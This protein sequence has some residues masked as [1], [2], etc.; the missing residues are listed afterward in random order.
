MFFALFS[1]LALSAG[2]VCTS[3]L[4]TPKAVDDMKLVY[5]Q[6]LAG[7]GQIAPKLALGTMVERGQWDCDGPNTVAPNMYIS[8]FKNYRRF[9]KYIEP[10]VVDFSSNCKA[11]DLT[12]VGQSQMKKLGENFLSYYYNSGLFDDYP[13]ENEVFVRAASDER[14]IRAAQ[15][16]M[17]GM[18]PPAGPNSSLTITVDEEA[19]V[20]LLYPCSCAC[21]EINEQNNK[22]TSSLNIDNDWAVVKDIAS[23]FGLDKSYDNLVSLAEWVV[24]YGCANIKNVVI[25][26]EI[27]TKC[28]E[29][30]KKHTYDR[31]A[32]NPALYASFLMREFIR[33]PK[34]M[35]DNK[36]TKFALFSTSYDSIYAV[37]QLLTGGKAQKDGFHFA[38]YIS[39]EVY[40][41]GKGEKSVRFTYNNT[42][43]KLEL[44]GGKDVVTL[45][46][47]LKSDYM[48]IND[49]CSEMP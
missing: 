24:A 45:D 27:F 3:D 32:K 2:N 35:N 48:K 43:I 34:N 6:V 37:H 46:S 9:K 19:G 33:I 40:E 49:Y 38:N 39:M 22:Y 20:S 8:N 10:Q 13:N 30:Y 23:K 16:F 14:Y 12:V 41:N 26:S 11:G 18:I 15:S 21:K 29:I 1:D 28:Q 4:S 25:T 17:H 44:M 7:V 36:G 5:A 31:Y 42:P 47:F